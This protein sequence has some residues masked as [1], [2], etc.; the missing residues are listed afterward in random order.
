MLYLLQV[1]VL[2]AIAILLPLFAVYLV[3]MV[4]RLGYLVAVRFV[5]MATAN[6]SRF[7][8]I[9]GNKAMQQGCGE[10]IGGQMMELAIDRAVQSRTMAQC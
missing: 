10:P 1:N 2:V 7:E 6:L 3:L 9:F 4:L 8:V 5:Q